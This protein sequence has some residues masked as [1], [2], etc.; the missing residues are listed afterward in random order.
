MLHI[1]NMIA[2]GVNQSNNLPVDILIHRNIDLITPSLEKLILETFFSQ[3]KCSICP[4]CKGP[5]RFTVKNLTVH[6]TGIILIKTSVNIDY[7]FLHLAN[8]NC[9]CTFA[10]MRS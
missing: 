2:D 6:V 7:P 3:F 8:N 4:H 1:L 9:P 10:T 5:I